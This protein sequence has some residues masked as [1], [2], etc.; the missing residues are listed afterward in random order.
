MVF[1]MMTIEGL[2]MVEIGILI[3]IMCQMVNIIFIDYLELVEYSNCL[4]W[5]IL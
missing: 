5:K 4:S 1:T 2:V 3:Y